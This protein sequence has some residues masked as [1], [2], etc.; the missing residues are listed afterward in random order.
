MAAASDIIQD[1]LEKLGI[2][3]AG[4]TINSND[5]SRCLTLLNNILDSWSNESLTTF[6]ELE[7]SGAMVVNQQSYQIGSG[8][9]DFNITRPL[10]IKDGP[11]AAYLQ[12]TNG[13]KYPVNVRP[14][15]QWNLITNPTQVTANV[16][17]DMFYDPQYPIGIIKVFPIPNI[18][19]TLYWDSYLQFTTFATVSTTVSLPPG[20]IKAM[21]DCLAEEAWPY[22]KP[23]VLQIPM[24]IVRSA[25]RSKG[26]IK[27]TNRRENVAVYDREIVSRGGGTYNPYSDRGY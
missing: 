18:S 6:E 14:R 20:Y 1:A 24:H 15:D 2:Y 22:F 21:V 5:Q 27:R 17:T 11:G 4:E 10:R 3:A 9:A 8:A 7:Q 23:D 16:P 19:W 25:M 26:N 12:D 13:N